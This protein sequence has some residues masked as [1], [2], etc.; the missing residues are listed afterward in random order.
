MAGSTSQ[1]RAM[2]GLI[3]VMSVV[4]VAAGLT[5]SAVAA[6]SGTKKGSS[7][8]PA[9][10]QANE[11]LSFRKTSTQASV[12]RLAKAERGDP[13]KEIQATAELS[14]ATAPVANSSPRSAHAIGALAAPLVTPTPPAPPF[15]ECPAI[16]LDTSCDI[17][18]VVT[19]SGTDV[20][21]DP[22]QGPYDG[23]DD[24]LTGVLNESGEPL[25]NLDLS[26][27]TDL[28]GFDGDGICTYTFAAYC[29]TAQYGYEG[30]DNTFSDIN[31]NDSGGVVNFT[32]PLP[33]G[34]SSYFSLEEALDASTVVSGGPTASEAG[35]AP[36]GSEHF[37]VCQ[38]ASPVN[39][40]TGDFWH[41]FT[42]FKIPGRGV[43]LNLTRTYVSSAAGTNGP[44]GYGWTDSYNWALNIDSSGNATVTQ[45]DGSTVEFNPT[46]SGTFAAAPRV[47]ASLVQN[48]DGSYTFTRFSDGI[49]YNFSSAGVLQSEV[50]RNGYV[51][52]LSYNG[53]Q[54]TSVS[55]PA[56]RQLTFAYTGSNISKITDPLGRTESFT[57]DTNGNLVKTTDPAGRSWSFSYDPN[58]L[59]L[60]MTDPNGGSTTNTYNTSDQVVSQANALGQ[61]TTWSY[62]G[63]PTSPGGGTTTITD[64]HGSVTVE[65]YANLE[66]QSVTTANGTA[67]AATTSYTY[68]PA[69]LGIATITDPNG[70]VTTNTYD[71]DGNELTTT[72]ALGNSSS[73]SYNGF[74]EVTSESTPL[75][76]TKTYSYDADG[77]LLSTSDALGGTTTLTYGD[78]THPGDITSI[79]DPDGRV[80]S[81]TYDAQGDEASV[82]VS[83]TSGVNDTTEYAYDSDG[84]RTCTASAD[85]VAK[86]ITCPSSSTHVAGT[87]SKTYDPDGEVTSITNPDGAV[88]SN[89]YD[90]DGNLTKTT[91][92]DGN[93]STTSFDLLDRKLVATVGVNGSTPSATT[94]TYDLAP[95]S[96]PCGSGV[97]GTTYCDAVTNASGGQTTTY[98]NAANNPIET[99]NP[100][101]QVTQ[102]SFD[103]AGNAISRIDAAGRTT[104]YTYDADNRLVGT[105]Y[106]D[107]TTPDVSYA[108]DADGN[109]QTMTDGTG[110]TTYSYD[111]DE[112]LLSSTDGA[113]ATVAY[114]YDGAGDVD[115][116]TYADG[117]VVTRTYDGAER[118]S[119]ISDGSGNTTTFAYDAN[120]NLTATVYP[121]GDTVSSAFDPADQMTSTGVVSTAQPSNQLATITYARDAAGQITQEVDSGGLSGS[122]AYAY[123]P[124]NRLSTTG[125]SSYAYDPLGDLTGL[126]SGATQ[127]FNSSQELT[128][129][130][131]AG[132]TSSYA[133]DA[134]GDR[135]STTAPNSST[136]YGY[137]QA[138]ELT[139]VAETPT[140]PV[141][142]GVTP[143][144]GPTAGGTV[145]TVAGSG[146]TNAS[147]VSFGSASATTFKVNSDSSI[148]ATSPV[149]SGAVDVTVTTPG[150]TSAVGPAD[151]FT[152]Q[153]VTSPPV[154]SS[155]SPSTGPASGGTG[156]TIAGSG[157][158][159]ATG[160][161]FGTTAAAS[162]KVNS[163]TSISA[164]SPAGTG[165][166]DVTVTAS[167]STSATSQADQ[168]TYVSQSSLPVVSAVTPATG[169][170]SGGTKVAITGSGLTGATKVTFGASAAETFKVNSSTS[171]SATSPPGTGSVDV[172]VATPLG[173]SQVTSADRFVYE[174]APS[175]PVVSGISPNQGPVKGGTSVT[176]TGSGLTGT[177][178][179]RFGK[180]AA[181][182]FK[183][184][185]D[186][187]VVATSPAGSGSVQVTVVASGK[188]SSTSPG[189]VFTY[190]STSSLPTVSRISPHSGPRSG[191]TSVSIFGLRLRTV[192]SVHFGGTRAHFTLIA[193]RDGAGPHLVA[194]SPQGRGVVGITVTSP[195]GT[196]RSSPGDQFTYT[197]TG[198]KLVSTRGHTGTESTNISSNHI[199]LD[200]SIASSAAKAVVRASTLTSQ[201][202]TYSY[203]GDGL[204]MAKVTG[205]AT[206]QFTWDNSQSTPPV[207]SDGVPIVLSDG[208]ADYV[209]GPGELPLEQITTGG[210]ISYYFHDGLGSTRLL[211]ASSGTI[212][213]SFTFSPYG[214][215]TSESGSDSTP[216]EFAGGYRD[217][218][219]GLYYLVNRY[220][221]PG[222]G[223]F[224]TEDPFAGIS[225]A[226]YGYAADDPIV[227]TDPLG[228]FC[229]LGHNPNGSCRGSNIK[230]DATDVTVGLGVVGLG[231][232]IAAAVVVSAPVAAVLTGLAIVAG[233][234]AALIGY[235]MSA[236]DCTVNGWASN[237]CSNSLLRSTID[238]LVTAVGA[239]L[240]DASA[241]ANVAARDAAGVSEAILE[242][243][244]GVLVDSTLSEL[245][246]GEA[247]RC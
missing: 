237:S 119:G 225:L 171:V 154:V 139:S 224:L 187:S 215:T 104:T 209:Y 163:A 175:G 217:S 203:N 112:R 18:V 196:S 26:G 49:A 69:T 93:V 168:F 22:S 57:Y 80:T 219:S 114:T 25:T 79:A 182:S 39:C 159:G 52:T 228:L 146:F 164:Q 167:G 156:I 66:L 145:V 56:G 6:T 37:T 140:A 126:P 90:A 40:A 72:D 129:S 75:G 179:V 122:T 67:A 184:K 123:D 94:Y 30:P 58:H 33:T 213:A 148:T 19:D 91:D 16:G 150:G 107:G 8:A 101:G 195:Q 205:G 158:T 245:L 211:L 84:E 202:A 92:P 2:R 83:P 29:S 160:V 173:P 137:N 155:I 108:Y 147:S 231:L 176:I 116:L 64:P 117:R 204:R 14:P 208:T 62:T 153:V 134:V 121:N 230:H 241:V 239:V 78:S 177:T 165:I 143:A 233:G 3:V 11:A 42:D 48:G 157:F 54:L 238:A 74:N 51:T 111:A 198:A 17:L 36:N 220:L 210:Q 124:Q 141:V 170:A 120:G 131:S 214:A 20:Y 191:H 4:V 235:G 236:Y 229:V 76:H 161:K 247:P 194:I 169:P 97:S 183:V 99:T 218:E 13:A 50:D 132:S 34:G 95:G 136:T 10:I 27:D 151:Q 9:R 226:P 109:R 190:L 61:T 59:L 53:S 45:D 127:A 115:S 24:T 5:V 197:K 105:S 65:D 63:D 1:R 85:A 77:N 207:L 135:T 71:A 172:T 86:S 60:A 98:Y 7:S 118:M 138:S 152:Y 166:V 221:D 110:T 180:A 232:G 246:P 199:V 200:S 68:D 38:S 178:A 130:T 133:Y 88:T 193:G 35:G 125:G 89:S 244:D 174:V 96:A 113:G 142:T 55:D 212:A 15:A 23:I 243:V 128:Q 181:K 103:A 44:L 31:A 12:E 185:S 41:Q 43:P 149:G 70:H 162:F 189:D 102:V 242:Y 201:S 192:T 106:S 227:N 21:Q 28:F 100:G 216:F 223:Q 82:S 186:S 206:Y 47:L 32:T 234:T 81:L 87:T 188:R 240:P 144:S 73:F 222:T 46:G